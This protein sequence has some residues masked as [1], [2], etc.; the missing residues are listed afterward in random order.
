MIRGYTMEDQNVIGKT[1]TPKL[2]E[3]IAASLC[4][5][6]ELDAP[7][8]VIW[9]EFYGARIVCGTI[10]YYGDIFSFI[11]GQRIQS[12]ESYTTGNLVV[13]HARI[14]ATL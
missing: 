14:C 1:G 4:L 2:R 7:R 10:I 12:E 13:L 8:C 5:P 11:T 6:F 3:R 9:R